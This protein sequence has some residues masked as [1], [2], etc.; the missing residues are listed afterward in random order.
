MTDDKPSSIPS[1]IEGNQVVLRPVT[2]ADLP[3]LLEIINK[4]GVAGRWGSSGYDMDKVRTEFLEDDE[5]VV[6]VIEVDRQVVGAVQYEQ[7]VDPDYRHASI[8]IFID[9]DWHGRG[10]GTDAVRTLA[11]HLVHDLGHHRLTID[12]AADNAQAIA[13]YKKVGFKPVGIMH[14]YERGRDGTWHDSLLM[15]LLAEELKEGT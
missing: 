8:D 13:C 6:F 11:R 1:I 4:P 3:R 15:D 7:E 10:L 2:E 14:N 9:P 12:P 5:I